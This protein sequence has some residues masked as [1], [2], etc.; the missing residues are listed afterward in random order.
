MVL[1]SWGSARRPTRGTAW[2]AAGGTPGGPA[3]GA[4]TGRRTQVA[5]R[6]TEG[7]LEPSHEVDV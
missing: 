2:G 1:S 5:P 4:A 3:G 7:V 6:A